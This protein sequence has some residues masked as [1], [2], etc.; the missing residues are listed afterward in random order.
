MSRMISTALLAL[1]TGCYTTSAPQ[2]KYT[3]TIEPIFLTEGP[4][5][6]VEH[7]VIGQVSA[8]LSSG[9]GGDTEIKRKLAEVAKKVGA[10]AVIGVHTWHA[11]GLLSWAAPNAA[12]TAIKFKGAKPDLSKCP[13][14]WY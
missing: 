11:L 12:G 1:L 14:E 6:G 9:Y 13:G 10:D 8:E 4:L 5:R 3:A 2:S 7:E